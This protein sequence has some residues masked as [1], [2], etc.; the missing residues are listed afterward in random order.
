MEG[1]G[2]E[3]GIGPEGQLCFIR[4]IAAQP[5][6]LH[7]GPGAL[8]HGLHP[9]EQGL[10]KP[11]VPDKDPV[12]VGLYE[13][14]HDLIH[15]GVRVLVREGGPGEAFLLHQLQKGVQ[16]VVEEGA[17]VGGLLLALG[18]LLGTEAVFQ[19]VGEGAAVE[20]LQPAGAHAGRG[21]VH[22]LRQGSAEGGGG[23]APRDGGLHPLE[24]GAVHVVLGEEGP[25]GG[26]LVADDPLPL[27]EGQLPDQPPEA[28]LPIR[29]IG[30]LAPAVQGLHLGEQ[31]ADSAKQ[32][33]GGLLLP[34]GGEG[35]AEV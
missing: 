34:V 28:P 19:I 5:H 27:V 30:A 12:V 3:G 20:L 21:P 15:Q 6:L 10:P 29:G 14:G 7:D 18:A 26:E 32:R 35:V 13:G 25:L 23:D 22:A 9:E 4:A 16:G 33:R 2:R 17:R 24:P 11:H 31:P 1:E 8:L